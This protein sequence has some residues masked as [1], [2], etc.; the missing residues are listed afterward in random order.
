MPEHP[1]RYNRHK[2]LSGSNASRYL[3]SQNSYHV[4][5]MPPTGKS[6]R[7]SNPEEMTQLDMREA[8]PVLGR[9]TV[10]IAT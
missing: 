5:S 6:D 7:L 2:N 4:A 3:Q 8:I 1:D 10:S 9:S